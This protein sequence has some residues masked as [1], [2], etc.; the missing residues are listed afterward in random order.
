MDTTDT[1]NLN[2]KLNKRAICKNGNTVINQSSEPD[3]IFLVE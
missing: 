3:T 1:G 2:G